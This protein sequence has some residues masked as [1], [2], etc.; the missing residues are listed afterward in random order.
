[1]ETTKLCE[2]LGVPDGGQFWV[3][4]MHWFHWGHQVVF[5]LVYEPPDSTGRIAFQIA[6]DDCR[7]M[8]WRIYAHLA[9]PEDANFAASGLVNLRL[10]EDRHRKPLQMLTDFFG[11]TASY[12]ALRV[13]RAAPT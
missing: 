4:D 1:M 9:A 12:G 2:T 7:D 11:L 3:T 8:H 6:M 13:E 10:G 5:D